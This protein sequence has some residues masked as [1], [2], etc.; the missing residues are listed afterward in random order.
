MST[1]CTIRQS[2][3]QAFRIATYIVQCI[4]QLYCQFTAGE[5]VDPGV[6]QSAYVDN[7]ITVGNSTAK[8]F[9]TCNSIP[10]WV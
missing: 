9:T 10:D 6:D 1:F 7:K 8:T 4:G 5:G 2:S 3:D